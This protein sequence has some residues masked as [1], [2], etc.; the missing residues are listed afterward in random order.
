MGEF[1]CTRECFTP[2]WTFCG[3]EQL[4]VT[5]WVHTRKTG[6]S[7]EPDFDTQ[8]FCEIVN[9]NWR[10]SINSGSAPDLDGA[11]QPDPCESYPSHRVHR[12]SFF[13]DRKIRR[14]LSRSSFFSF[15]S[16]RAANST[17]GSRSSESPSNQFAATP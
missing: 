7:K 8:R 16:S 4:V 12:S 1:M 10:I 14:N 11:T 9:A 6:T 17:T 15:E 5:V 13:I 2:R 3:H